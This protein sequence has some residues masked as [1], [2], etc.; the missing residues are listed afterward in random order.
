MKIQAGDVKFFAVCKQST[1]PAPNPEIPYAIRI[2][3]I[4]QGGNPVCPYC[5]WEMEIQEEAELE[6]KEEPVTIDMQYWKTQLRGWQHGANWF[7]TNLLDLISRADM[8]NRALIA[9]GF[10]EAVL[11]YELWVAGDLKIHDDE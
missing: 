9:K 11:A 6:V 8:G 4:E 1:C 5:D 10:P 3:D 2:G 7:T